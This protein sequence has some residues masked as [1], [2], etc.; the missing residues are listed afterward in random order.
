[1]IDNG[2]RTEIIVC[3]AYIKLN[4]LFIATFP[5]SVLSPP[6]PSP[7]QFRDSSSESCDH[8][9][10]FLFSYD[11]HRL[12]G[13]QRRPKI[14]MNPTVQVAYDANWYRWHTTVLRIPVVKCWLGECLHNS[15]HIECK[16]TE[17]RS[18]FQFRVV[19]SGIAAP[20]GGLDLGSFRAGTGLLY[21]GRPHH[22]GTLSAIAR[23][24]HSA[25]G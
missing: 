13:A 15:L 2:T 19:E 23:H 11:L 25:L 12:Y 18:A 3:Y 14:Y 4:L 9:E 21:L 22:S 17:T 20:F 7:I 8:S 24:K 5:G 16:G 10:C 1:M 6:L